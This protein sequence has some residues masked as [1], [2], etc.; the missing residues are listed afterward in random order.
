[1]IRVSDGDDRNIGEEEEEEEEGGIKASDETLRH[2]ISSGTLN[3][4]VARKAASQ[5]MKTSPTLLFR[6]VILNYFF[7]LDCQWIPFLSLFLMI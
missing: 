7:R 1:M 6:I 5:V 4:D 2:L 3:W